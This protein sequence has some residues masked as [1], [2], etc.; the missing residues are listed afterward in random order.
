M[1][2][3]EFWTHLD[4]QRLVAKEP[5]NGAYT[6]LFAGLS[7][8][9]AGKHDTDWGKQVCIRLSSPRVNPKL[10]RNSCPVWED[11]AGAQGPVRPRAWPEVLGMD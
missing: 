4:I 6:E 1:P 2:N 5:V 11:Y 7:E 8:D 10:I 9:V 3:F